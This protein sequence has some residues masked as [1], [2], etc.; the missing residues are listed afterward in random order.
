MISPRNSI[1][2]TSEYKT[3]LRG[4]RD[5]KELGTNKKGVIAITVKKTPRNP[6]L[7]LA[8]SIK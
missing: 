8:I 2:P 7:I 1:R 6:L 4:K 5:A 3:V